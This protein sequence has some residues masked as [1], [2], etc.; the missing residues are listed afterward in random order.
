MLMIKKL[1]HGL[2]LGKFMPLH[3]GHLHLLHFANESCH[4]LTIMVCSQWYE[5]IPGDIRHSWMKQMFPNANV[6]HQYEPIQQEPTDDKDEKFWLE[7]KQAIQRHCI[8]SD[9][10]A[11]FGS[12]D[13]GWKLAKTL[14]CDYV[15]VDRLREMVP[16]SGTAI[17]ENPMGN[18]PYIPIVCRPYFV[19]RFAVLGPESSGKSTLVTALG[20]AF[21]TIAVHEYARPYFDE[22]VRAGMRAPGEFTVEDLSNVARGQR[23]AEESLAFRA[24]RVMFVD[25]DSLTTKIWM[26][27]LYPGLHLPWL[28]QDALERKYDY[29]FVLDP[30]DVPYEAQDQRVMKDINERVAFKQ[31]IVIELEKAKRPFIILRGSFEA[32][33]KTVT[34]MIEK[35]I[36]GVF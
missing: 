33:V 28:E 9:F 24:N 27:H 31:N 4:K 32:K 18:W 3:E 17:R 14:G 2:V 1:G 12:E 22:M 20:E 21:N 7:W 26:N 30:R 13:Y 36:N 19:K 23:V 29:S 6:V 15:P 11:V 25:T 10:D 35:F 8:P 34:E 5:P 16:T